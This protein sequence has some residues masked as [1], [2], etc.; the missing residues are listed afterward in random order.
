MS[1]IGLGFGRPF[2]NGNRVG[3]SAIRAGGCCA[4]SCSGTP[5]SGS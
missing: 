4:G 1:G 3:G 5:A 2:V